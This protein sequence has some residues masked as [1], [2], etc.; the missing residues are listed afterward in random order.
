MKSFR[1]FSVLCI[2][3][4][5]LLAV[6][7]GATVIYSLDDGT[8]EN[9]VG[10]VLGCGVGVDLIWGNHFLRTPGGEVI[11]S[12][13]AAFGFSSAAA[14]AMN[15]TSLVAS[16]WSDPNGDGNPSDAALLT[17]APGVVANWAMD[18]FNTYDIPDTLVG[19]SFFVGISLLDPGNVFA[20]RYDDSL[21]GFGSW[22]G[23]G[24]TMTGANINNGAQGWGT[25]LV[26]AEADAVPEPATLFL[27]G[28][29]LLGLAA[30]RRRTS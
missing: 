12:V 11:R 30:R 6:P 14:A 16:L 10:C 4:L 3:G 29:G 21:L 28:S 25:Y 20:A 5:A 22:V 24:T 27:L 13:S 26:R 23:F 18:T 7:A 9:G 15:G 1:G 17:S 19:P 2:L 8:G